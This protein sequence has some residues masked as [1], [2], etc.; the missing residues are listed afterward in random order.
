MLVDTKKLHT[1]KAAPQGLDYTPSDY[2]RQP[3]VYVVR[4]TW[5]GEDDGDLENYADA[6][7]FAFDFANEG[8]E[9]FTAEDIRRW[10]DSGRRFR[11]G[12]DEEY[13]W[14]T[15][16]PEPMARDRWGELCPL[17]ELT[18]RNTDFE[19]PFDC[20]PGIDFPATLGR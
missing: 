6:F 1:V 16:L 17:S 3:D 5:D 14:F 10:F 9:E 20:R 4:V 13:Y 15:P 12:S 8:E 2:E 19:P 11:L 18:E 7:K